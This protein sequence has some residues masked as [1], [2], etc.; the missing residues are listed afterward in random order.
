MCCWGA[1]GVRVGGV[2]MLYVGFGGWLGLGVACCVY[3]IFDAVFGTDWACC[4]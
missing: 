4:S 2:G 3:V 1:R